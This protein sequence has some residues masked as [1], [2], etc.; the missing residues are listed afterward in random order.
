MSE[1]QPAAV[2]AF[3]LTV[4]AKISKRYPELKNELLLILKELRSLPQLPSLKVRIK[5][6]LK[7]LETV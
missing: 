3:A 1:T 7:E 4:A 2:R 6:A 5:M